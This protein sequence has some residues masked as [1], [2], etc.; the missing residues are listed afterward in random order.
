M[1]TSEP[2]EQAAKNRS[3]EQ[4][5]GTTR[6]A[7]LLAGAAALAVPDAVTAS[8]SESP[9][10]ALAAGMKGDITVPGATGTSVAFIA[11][12]TVLRLEEKLRQ[13]VVLQDQVLATIANAI[14]RWWSGLEDPR[15]PIGSFLFLGPSGVGK[16]ALAKALAEHL[17]GSAAAMLRLD[18]R[19]YTGPDSVARLTA[20]ELTVAVERQPYHV[21]LFDEVEKAHPAVLAGIQQILASGSLSNGQGRTVDFRNTVVIMSTGV[22]GDAALK[23][24]FPPEFLSRIGEIVTFNPLDRAQVRRALAEQQATS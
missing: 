11:P 13:R 1:A 10:V 3:E 18:M 6:R 8:Q 22:R 2:T 16:T 5:M 15:R 23:R 17:F 19:E 14:R 4:D 21:L 24:A 20:G 12:A 9:T 7:A